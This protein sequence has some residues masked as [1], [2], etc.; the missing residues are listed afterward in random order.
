MGNPQEP[1]SGRGR[2]GNEPEQ[3]LEERSRCIEVGYMQ[4]QVLEA[5]RAHERLTVEERRHRFESAT[6]RWCGRC[7]AGCGLRGGSA[8]STTRVFR[9][10]RTPGARAQQLNRDT[11]DHDEAP[12]SK[13]SNLFLHE[14]R[15]PGGRIERL[16]QEAEVIDV[17]M[18]LLACARGHQ[19]AN[20][21]RAGMEIDLVP[22]RGLFLPGYRSALE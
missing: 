9:S 16:G 13:V 1:K 12:A 10:R 7:R 17:G 6:A 14:S 5:V 2:V 21:Q 22:Q 4:C 11:A 19:G 15:A 20:R 18:R 8:S 3:T